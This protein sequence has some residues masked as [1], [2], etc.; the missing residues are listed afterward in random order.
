M[1][2]LVLVL[3]NRCAPGYVGNPNVQ[4]GRCLPQSKCSLSLEWAGGLRREPK[5]LEEGRVEVGGLRYLRQRLLPAG[6]LPE[7][8]CSL[9]PQQTKPHWWS[10]SIR[11]GV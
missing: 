10:R 9:P 2:E 7:W 6:L 11:L 1:T 5:E 3:P 4:G 8:L